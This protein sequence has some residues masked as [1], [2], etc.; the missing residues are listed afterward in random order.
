[1]PTTL[2]T[3]T[4]GGSVVVGGA[5]VVVVLLVVV[6]FGAARGVG[7]PLHEARTQAAAR[8]AQPMSTG[9]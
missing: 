6:L 1:M 3:P 7:E 2:G 4:P 8:R 5:V 9:R